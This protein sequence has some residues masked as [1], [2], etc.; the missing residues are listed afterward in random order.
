[1][2]KIFLDNN[3][4]GRSPNISVDNCTGIFS[5]QSENDN[6]TSVYLTVCDKRTKDLHLPLIIASSTIVVFLL[7]SCISIYVLHSIL[8]PIR[9]L[10]F[11]RKC[12]FGTIWPKEK[13]PLLAP[14]LHY[15]LEPSKETLEESNEKLKNKIGLDLIDVSIKHGYS[16]VVE[17][18]LS[19]DVGHAVSVPLLRKA[20]LEGDIKVIKILLR[21][22]K[23]SEGTLEVDHTKLDTV[24]N[25]LPK[26]RGMSL[27]N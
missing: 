19:P 22:A 27:H 9:M 6:I 23:G 21:A 1:M 20:L 5:L 3:Y 10:L 26:E 13:K 25:A 24:I 17:S 7:F 2:F 12:C 11:S 4:C 15:I 14:V 18:I 8:N 16:Q